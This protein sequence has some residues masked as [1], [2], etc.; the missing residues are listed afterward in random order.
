MLHRCWLCR[1]LAGTQKQIV[2]IER[3]VRWMQHQKVQKHWQNN[4]DF[5]KAATKYQLWSTAGN[6]KLISPQSLECNCC[7]FWIEMYMEWRNHFIYDGWLKVGQSKLACW[8]C[9]RAPLKCWFTQPPTNDNQQFIIC[10]SSNQPQMNQR[11]NVRCC[12]LTFPDLCISLV[13]H[14]QRKSWAYRCCQTEPRPS[15]LP[16]DSLVA[17]LLTGHRRTLEVNQRT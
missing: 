8:L 12:P 2:C 11:M 9:I 10:N 17:G 4:V 1:Q 15:S 6:Y 5:L 3:R 13:K 16:A 7:D 14:C